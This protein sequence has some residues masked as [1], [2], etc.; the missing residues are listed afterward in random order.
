MRCNYSVF[1]YCLHKKEGN[2][3]MTEMTDNGPEITPPVQQ[4]PEIPA[5]SSNA[6]VASA[7]RRPLEAPMTAPAP[8]KKESN[9]PETRPFAIG[10][11]YLTEGETTNAVFVT[12]YEKGSNGEDLLV[13]KGEGDQEG[14][15]VSYDAVSYLPEEDKQTIREFASQSGKDADTMIALNDPKSTSDQLIDAAKTLGI[16]QKMFLES[17]E[18]REQDPY[19]K[20]QAKNRVEELKTE[21]VVKEEEQKEQEEESPERKKE[22]NQMREELQQ[23]ANELNELLKDLES[24]KEG[25]DKMHEAEERME[26]IKEKMGKIGKGLG[27]ALLVL[28]VVTFLAWMRL[29]AALGGS[30]KR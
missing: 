29:Q 24:G 13:L 19:T 1:N 14:K 6:P 20:E 18:K 27:I 17:L 30:G 4:S 22:Q 5:G 16:D 9:I 2:Y 10:R 7:P 25:S 26:A 23:E 3:T 28:I 15:K 21:D 12:G 11:A 8:E